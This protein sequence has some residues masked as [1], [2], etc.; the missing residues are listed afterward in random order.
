MPR[1]GTRGHPELA[2]NLVL[3]GGRGSGKS[4][5]AKRIARAN[6]H[7]MLFS[8]DALI[9][10]EAG[11]ASIRDIVAREGWPGFR[12]RELAVVQK[13]AAIPGGA[14]V[15]A[16]GGVVVELDREGRERYSAQKVDALRRH[17]RIV[18]LH[19]DVDSLA[20]R[21]SEEADHRPVLSGGESFQQMMKRRDPWYRRAAHHVIEC[22]DRSKGELADAILAWFYRDQGIS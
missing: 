4:S 2:R 11:G 9:R 6:R 17:G 22:D 15:D 13:V 14:L 21:A 12:A 10:Y 7:F 19:R 5:L 18:Y 20:E 3:I 8:L 16:G 1:M